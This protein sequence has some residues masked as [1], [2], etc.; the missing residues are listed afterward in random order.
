MKGLILSKIEFYFFFLMFLYA[1][2]DPDKSQNFMD[3]FFF[4]IDS[5]SSICVYMHGQ[6]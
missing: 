5:T 4:H 6:L 1:G 3:F 2:G